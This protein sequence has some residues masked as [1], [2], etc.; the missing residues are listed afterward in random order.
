LQ[1][2]NAKQKTFQSLPLYLQ[3]AH[4]DA[5]SNTLDKKCEQIKKRLQNY[6]DENHNYCQPNMN[7]IPHG[8]AQESAWDDKKNVWMK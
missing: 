1:K 5:E 7:Y 2:E 4:L 8:P 6:P 3:K